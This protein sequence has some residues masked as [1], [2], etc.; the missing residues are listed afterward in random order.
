MMRW[1]SIVTVWALLV[2]GAP[3]AFA[4]DEAGI[5]IARS[6][7]ENFQ[8][9]HGAS[10]EQ[11]MACARNK[12]RAAGGADCQRVRW[13]FP[14]GYSGAMSY[15]ANRDITTVTLLCGAPS[16]AALLNMLAAQCRIDAAATECRLMVLWS[17][18][19]SESA[20]TDKLGK[21]S[22]D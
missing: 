6:P 18:D 3:A 14:A 2:G 9:C 1:A 19:G 21:N 17:P 13:C 16:E 7:D 4:Q 12:C 10:P 11:T 20:R 15:L 22:A 8:A 5:A